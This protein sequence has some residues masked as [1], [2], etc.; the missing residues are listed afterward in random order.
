MC[1]RNGLSGAGLRSKTRTPE[2]GVGLSRQLLG[3]VVP[4]R[5]LRQRWESE[6]LRTTCWNGKIGLDGG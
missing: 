5:S 6:K 1:L 2:L 3:Q 4:A